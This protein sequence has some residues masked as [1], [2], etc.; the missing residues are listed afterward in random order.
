MNDP[1]QTWFERQLA[2]ITKDG[3]CELCNGDDAL[4]PGAAEEL[5]KLT[6]T[7]RAALQNA[8]APQDLETKP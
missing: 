4:P 3:P 7:D 2:A 6:E 5:A 1:L 8:F